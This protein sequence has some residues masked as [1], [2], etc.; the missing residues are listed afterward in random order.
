MEAES[1]ES[2]LND[3]LTS[4][5]IRD[6]ESFTQPVL[7]SARSRSMN[8]SLY[9]DQRLLAISRLGLAE[10]SAV[11]ETLDELLSVTQPVAIQNAAV[12][13]LG[14]F[15]SDDAATQLIRV[16]PR[17]N[18][19][20]RRKANE[21]L[22]ARTSWARQL[23]QAVSSGDLP[24]T[25]IAAIHR[26]KLLRH[27]DAKIAELAKQLFDEKSDRVSVVAKYQSQLK[28]SGDPKR[29][30]ELFRKVCSSCHRL[31]GLGKNVGP[32]LAPL[33]NRG[34]AYMLTNILD[35]NREVDPRYE[36]YTVITKDGRS[37]SGLIGSD[38]ATSF[39]L[40]QADGNA[41]SILKNEIEEL[42]ATGRSLM[43]EGFERDL[44]EEGLADLIAWL[45]RHPD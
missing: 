10:Y 12:E 33:R 41:V 16:A 25:Q 11:A 39:Q 29:G 9:L 40:T 38:S 45:I 21:L 31:D 20:G 4:M 19:V 3:W 28:Q 44:G 32:E 26:D 36:S 14:R 17:L 7:D 15:S 8:Q 35:P 2:P 23:L 18:P 42:E 34:A 30:R 6:P 43:P 24:P 1:V 27:R 37:I 13:V 5:E 22:V